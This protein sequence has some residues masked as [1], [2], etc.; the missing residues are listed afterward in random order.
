M[1]GPTLAQTLSMVLE[2]APE[3]YSYSHM[4]YKIYKQNIFLFLSIE[5]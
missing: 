1:P 5:N 4:F 2:V 3:M